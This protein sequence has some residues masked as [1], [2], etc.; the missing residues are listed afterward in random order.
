MDAILCQFRQKL[1]QK[2]TQLREKE[3]ELQ[4]RNAYIGRL[5]RQLQ[6]FMLQLNKYI[7]CFLSNLFVILLQAMQESLDRA[8]LQFLYGPRPPIIKVQIVQ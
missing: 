4:Q 3:V 7:L 8:R 6:V 2:E 1:Q 5:Q